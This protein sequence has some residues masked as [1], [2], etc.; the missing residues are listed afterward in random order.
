MP[1]HLAPLP[2]ASSSVDTALLWKSYSVS[3]TDKEPLLK[4][5]LEALQAR[6]C[7][8]R[9]A[10]SADK[11]PF[12]IVFETPGGERHGVL[13]YAF[14]ANTRPTRNRP[15]DEHRFQVKYGSELKGVLNVSID[16]S[17]LITT[18]FL[19]INPKSE[20]F[21]AADPV[22]NNPSPMSRSIEF[23]AEHVQQILESGWAA[24]ERDRHPPKTKSRPTPELDEDLRTQVMIGGT[25]SH[26]LDLI[27]LERI[28]RGLDPGERHLLAD[29]ILQRPEKKKVEAASHRLLSE[30]DLPSEALF[31]LIEGASRL[32]MAVRGW[33]AEQKLEDALR[34]LPGVSDCHRINEE[35]MPD[36]RLRWKGGPPILV[37][38]K[39]VLRKT[40]KDGLAK[41]DF[42][43]TRASK[44]DPCSRYYSADDFAVLA[45][46]LHATTTQ[47]RF[48]YALTK[49]LPK[50][51]S[52]R[53]RLASNVTISQ[54]LFTDDPELVFSKCS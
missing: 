35:G 26:L 22:M 20:I 42:Q 40:T 16:P 48:S 33:V 11:A 46:C 19:G 45:A 53:N 14:F 2:E 4:F 10:T 36:V 3:R 54:P 15:D 29:T 25:K 9:F 47:W 21:V 7:E 18:I 51:A 23:K 28:A 5:V 6:D 1:D 41:L 34:K 8:I 50:H 30:L 32:K 12:Y 13:V 52:C 17:A 39:N 38:C 43:R 37:E 44:S 27:M 24:W 31:D 49:E